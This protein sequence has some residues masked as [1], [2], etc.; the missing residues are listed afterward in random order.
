MT[1]VIPGALCR[2]AENQRQ[3]IC[4]HYRAARDMA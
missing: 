1:S 3:Q 2:T 4:L